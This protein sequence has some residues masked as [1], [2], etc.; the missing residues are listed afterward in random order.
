ME[1]KGRIV[2]SN[3]NP[4]QFRISKNTLSN[5]EITNTNNPNIIKHKLI[6]E[7]GAPYILI[8]TNITLR[9]IKLQV[10]TGASISLVA[11]D[12]LSTGARKF[13]Y[14]ADLYGIAG[15]EVSN[16]TEGMIN[17]IVS[18]SGHWLGITLHLVNRKYAGPADGY[19]GYDFISLYKANIIMDELL[20]CININ[21]PTNENNDTISSPVKGDETETNPIL[22]KEDNHYKNI[23][24]KKQKI[25]QN[26][27]DNKTNNNLILY[28]QIQWVSFT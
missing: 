7:G 23:P 1:H 24:I 5:P 10:D 25:N 18:F 28:R 19:L 27:I 14:I 17:G 22:E 21:I 9:P 3:I 26:N 11:S 8:N 2:S 13:D 16:K 4:I 15:K 12:T 20:L 6:N